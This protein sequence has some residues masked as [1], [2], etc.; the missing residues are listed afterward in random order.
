MVEQRPED[1]QAAHYD[2][3]AERYEAEYDDLG[4]RAYRDRFIHAAMIDA[5]E[6]VGARVLEAMSGS[7]QATRYLKAAG[8]DVAGLDISEAQIERFRNRWPGC[9]G[10]CASIF[11][12]G[13]EASS[14]DGIVIIGGLHHVH[15]RVP[16]ALAEAHRLLRPGGWLC[17]MEPHSG[18]LPD[19]ARRLWYRL[20]PLFEENEAS[21]DVEALEREFSDRFVFESKVHRGNVAFLLVLNSMVFRIPPGL[22]RWISPPLLGLEFALLPLQTRWNSCFVVARWRKR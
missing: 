1:A 9:D 21:I 3:L 14:F 2:S 7:G 16:D 13:L 5:E 12:S 20:D 18:S 19:R 15:P 6:L 8:A 10:I 22:K 11:E 17:F 4:S